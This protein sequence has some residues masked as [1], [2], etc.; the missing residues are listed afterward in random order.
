MLNKRLIK[1]NIV[2][3]LL[4]LL[5]YQLIICR[6]NASGK[7]TGNNYPIILVNGMAGFERDKLF[8][9]KYYGGLNDIQ[10]ILNR[11]G[12]TTLSAFTGPFASDWDQAIEIYYYI[13]GG[14]VDYGAAHSKRFGHKRFGQTYPG[15]YP[16]WD[17]V[18][19]VHFVGF[20]TG[21]TATR[22]L[23]ELLR[24]GDKDEIAYYE[25]HQ[26]ERISPLFQG[27]DRQWIHSITSLAT[28]HNGST[29]FEIYNRNPVTLKQFILKVAAMSESTYA[30]PA[31]Y[32]F[33]MEQ[34]G[35]RRN[36]D[37]SL[38]SYV[39]RV[40]DS[41][42]WKTED[43]CFYTLTRKG[44]VDLNNRSS[45]HPDMYYFSYHGDSTY[46]G[47]N[48][49]YYPIASTNVLYIYGALAIGANTDPTLPYGYEAWRA[50]D[51]AANVI[52]AKYPFNQPYKNFDG[53]IERGVWNAYPTMK[54]WDHFDFLGISHVVDF[55][56]VETLYTNIA[57]TLKSLPK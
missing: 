24:Y 57:R 15:I 40:V 48:G 25:E 16:E 50:S 7:D 1:F 20:S 35:I 29:A 19:K 56:P 34:W 46:K 13:K 10:T 27:S 36:K 51:G 44:A 22:L 45:A 30:S 23:D 47:S 11:K 33:K 43:M 2:F 8:G 9:I 53:T 21:G 5:F 14:T 54:G 31:I 17:G 52:S 4:I 12:L 42:I 18:N 32:D 49:R 26:E 28:A 6:I 37:E 55:K 38:E 3:T 41:N 39:S